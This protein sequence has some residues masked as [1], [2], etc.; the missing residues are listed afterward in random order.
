[1]PLLHQHVNTGRVPELKAEGFYRLNDSWQI[2]TA[3]RDVDVFG[4]TPGVGLG[5]FH[6]EIRRQ[7]T[8]NPVLDAGRRKGLFYASSEIEKILQP[9]LEKSVDQERHDSPDRIISL[10]SPI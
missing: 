8:D 5:L 9:F 10:P 1:L 2:F 6:I 4:Q 3:D 7:A